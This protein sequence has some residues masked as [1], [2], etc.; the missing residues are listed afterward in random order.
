M[1]VALAVTVV[2]ARL[3]VVAGTVMMTVVAVRLV[4][5]ALGVTLAILRAVWW[6]WQGWWQG[7]T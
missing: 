5:V 4:A 3:V 2:V 7:F 6:Q 1:V